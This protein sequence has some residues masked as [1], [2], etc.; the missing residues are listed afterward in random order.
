M[1]K[2]SSSSGPGTRQ[3][4]LVGNTIT[5]AQDI[6]AIAKRL[7][8]N[9]DIFVEHLKVVF[10]GST[11]P[12]QEQLKNIF[13][14]RREKVYNA[15]RCL[16]ANH[17][18]YSDV[19]LSNVDLPIDDIP[20]QVLNLLHQ[21]DDPDNEDANSN[22]T[23]TPQTDLNDIPADTVVMNSSGIIDMEGSSVHSND[24]MNSAIHSLQGTL[25]VPHGSIP[26]NEYNNPNMW[27]GAYPWLFP[28]GKGGPEINRRVK[29]GLKAYM[30]HLLLLEDRKFSQDTSMIFHAFN[31]LQKR[32]VSLHTSILVRQPGFQATAARIDSL[33]NESLEQALKAIENNTPVTDPNLNTLTK[34]LSS[35]GSHIHGSPYQKSSNRRE[36]FGLMI[37]YGT[38]SLW[39]TIS[40]AVV[41]S[42]IFM[43]IAGEAIDID[44]SNIPAHVER[45]KLVANN[46][47]AAA[48]YYNTV[49]DAFTK[50]L[51]G[52]KQ[53]NGGTFGYT[54]AFY[55][56]TEEQGTGTLHNHML[57]WFYG[58]K[59]ASELKSL[60]Q[61]EMFKE[62][63]KN[64]L[65]RIIKQGYL[66]TDNFDVDLDVSDVSCKNPVNPNDY[67]NHNDFKEALN[68]DVNQLVKV[69]NT[70]SCRGTCY[71]Y[72]TNKECRF[73]YPRDL[74]PETVFTDE[75]TISMKRTNT[76]INN[77]NPPT[78]TCVRSN[79]DIKF[80]PSGKDGKNIA[81]YVSDY[82]TKSQLSTHQILPL[83]VA[84]RQQ[85]DLSNAND[86]RSVRSKAMITKCLN[87]I[88]TETEISAS[89][90]CHFLLGYSDAKTSHKFTRL[91]MHTAEAWLADENK[92]YDANLDEAIPLTEADNDVENDDDHVDTDNE[93]ND[94][95]DDNNDDD[96]D[97]TCNMYSISTGNAGLVVVNQ[98]IDYVNRGEELSDMCL[99]EYCE[100]VYKTKIQE[101]DIEKNNKVLKEIADEKANKNKKKYNFN[102]KRKTGPKARPKYLFSNEHPQS[103]THWQIVR[104][105]EQ[106]VV[107][108]LSKLPP[109]KNTNELKYQKCM[110]LLF[111]PFRV[112]T[113]LF[114]GISWDES[115]E[116]ANFSSQCAVYIENIQEMHIGIQEKEDNRADEDNNE[117]DDDIIDQSDGLDPDQP[118]D[119]I[120]KD[121]HAQTTSALDI[122]KSTGWLEE[123]TS[124]HQTIQPLCEN[125]QYRTV[126]YSTVQKP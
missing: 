55:G 41:H 58:F 115:Y 37:Q 72:R 53:L 83:I 82:A 91:N 23:Y 19:T 25:Y 70:H 8:A 33:T 36:I 94:D 14:V 88:T 108:A 71:K 86:D 80:V 26:L 57:V 4:G 17:P 105:D 39:I 35:A 46:P 99:Y 79:H 103:E 117:N 5:F 54:T 30:K 102:K 85:V 56:M 95:D 107:P 64:Y 34:S 76:M 93:D 84:S 51:L 119:V 97:D 15:V 92:K 81:F 90:V 10:I 28:Y 120:E 31:I 122:I 68:L 63:L 29:V 49:I 104:K 16:I 12:T 7:P 116:T 74:V 38:P 61:D 118:I 43:Q 22:T 6:V 21:H 11:R 24:Q 45:A 40:P 27:L 32:D 98:M 96:D 59:S 62:R 89:H 78:M 109:N 3:K 69:A 44:F 60:L 9:P 66:D 13:T 18:L 42:P 67:D 124:N 125:V 126:Q 113:D 106:K 2:L 52:Y 110:L 112:F 114:N 121:L 101:G 73:G 50:Y 47:V 100:K 65:E 123:S 75:N 1:V 87:R 77:F 48:I 111:K 20:E